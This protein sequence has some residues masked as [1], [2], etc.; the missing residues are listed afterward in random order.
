MQDVAWGGI[1]F[2]LLAEA[3]AVD[4]HFQD[5]VVAGMGN[6]LPGEVHRVNV[7]RIRVIMQDR[8]ASAEAMPLSSVEMPCSKYGTSKRFTT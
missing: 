5:A 1:T 4:R 3:Q 7:V 8:A 2:A 6:H